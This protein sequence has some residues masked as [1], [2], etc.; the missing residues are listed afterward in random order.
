METLYYIL[1]A[2]D[3]TVYIGKTKKQVQVLWEKIWKPSSL[4]CPIHFIFAKRIDKRQ[5]LGSG[6]VAKSQEPKPY[7]DSRR[8]GQILS[9]Q[10][11]L[12]S[13]LQKAIRRKDTNISLKSAKTYMKRDMKGFLRRFIIIAAEDVYLC[14]SVLLPFVFFYKACHGNS[15]IFTKEICDYILRVVYSVCTCDSFMEYE[16][17]ETVRPMDPH[18]PPSVALHIFFNLTT[19]FLQGDP[20]MLQWYHDKFIDKKISTEIPIVKECPGVDQVDYLLIRDT[21][22]YALDF[23]NCRSMIP[24]IHKMLKGK[25]DEESIKQIIWDYRSRN[26]V[27]KG[28]NVLPE[29]PDCIE[30]QVLK[31][32]DDYVRKML[33]REVMSS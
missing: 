12:K 27:R 1:Y 8:D 13:C 19:F 17:Q 14:S 33:Q 30:R 2:D 6:T 5:F 15:F 31:L 26:N 29:S 20:K 18:N 10:S 11:Y 25:V 3:Y 9:R 7:F 16:K 21:P 32:A 28:F 4:E 24:G 23:H 22:L